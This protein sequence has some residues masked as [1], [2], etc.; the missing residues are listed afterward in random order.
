MSNSII[1][2]VSLFFYFFVTYVLSHYKKFK[3]LTKVDRGII[4]HILKEHNIKDLT[5][6][7]IK[8]STKNRKYFI[9]VLKKIAFSLNK[10]IKTIKREI[11]GGT[12]KQLD[13]FYRP[14]L[15]YAFNISH[16]KYR[17]RITKKEL[18]L[19]IDNNTKLPF[20]IARLLNNKFSPYA[21]IQILKNKYNINFSI[22]TLYNYIHKDL[23]KFVGY[24]KVDNTII[25]KSKGNRTYNK[26]V[27]KSGGLSIDD[28][29]D[30]VNFREILGH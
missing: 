11:T 27:I 14:I 23:F 10:S 6:Y 1:S 22:Q 24:K 25:Y 7:I 30:L 28:R 3:H 5:K 12:I 17:E 8:P 15:I 9:S 29:E 26:R 19:K 18:P 13:I 20:E 16:D 2:N 4:S 21:I